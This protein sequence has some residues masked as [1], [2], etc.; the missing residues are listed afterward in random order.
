M[1][2]MNIEAVQQ[3]EEKEND[4]SDASSS[5]EGSLPSKRKTEEIT[6]A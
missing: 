4:D 1:K 5:E 2:K 3:I 6:I